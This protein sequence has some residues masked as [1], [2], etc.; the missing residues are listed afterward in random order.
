MFYM[1]DILD[2]IYFCLCCMFRLVL[3][4][5]VC[6]SYFLT[7]LSM[8][9]NL[10]QIFFYYLKFMIL[11]EKSPIYFRIANVSSF[12]TNLANF[13]GE[14]INW[15]ISFK[16]NFQKKIISVFYLWNL[17]TLSNPYNKCQ[18]PV[19]SNFVLNIAS[20]FTK[21]KKIKSQF[22]LEDHMWGSGTQNS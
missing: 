1:F 6:F 16:T 11:E 21:L 5:F 20:N 3:I 8:G 13:Q 2:N 4:C 19:F 18:L 9:S 10:V 14:S 7:L 17:L 22:W 12:L 15:W